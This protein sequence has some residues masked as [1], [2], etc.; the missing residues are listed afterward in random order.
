[1]NLIQINNVS[2]KFQNKIVLDD[3]SIDITIGITGLLGINGSGK[4]TLIKIL[5]GLLNA[6]SGEC[7]FNNEKII[8]NSS[9][10][11]KNIGYLPQSPGLYHRMNIYDFLDYML[12]LSRWK[13]KSERENRINEIM[14]RL[15]L[16][17]YSNY[18]IGN[19][20]GGTRQRVAIAQALIHNPQILFL[21]EPSNNLD[22]DERNR[23]HEYLLLKRSDSIII[24]IGHIINEM[25]N[26]CSRLLIIS[27][28]Q[29]KFNGTTLELINLAENYVK[30]I[31]VEKN[32]YESELKNCLKIIT[33]KQDGSGLVKIHFDGRFSDTPGSKSVQADL[34]EAYKILLNSCE[35][36]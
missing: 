17:E 4:S 21:D 30:E 6:D 3:V 14:E 16:I 33:I 36:A 9:E 15:N 23:F 26:F 11:H 7:F 1:M 34:E 10:W 28:A 31:V 12:L 13:N 25:F 8:F 27:G 2:K 24:Y 18:S 35:L 5:A 32:H 20:S 29:I 22:S 19:L